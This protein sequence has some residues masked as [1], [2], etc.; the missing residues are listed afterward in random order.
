MS[1]LGCDCDIDSILTVSGTASR[2][3]SFLSLESA[4]IRNSDLIS[5][6][7]TVL[8][9]AFIRLRLRKA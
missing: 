7:V 6:S 9:M 1:I 4:V 5:S 3:F 2:V 8:I